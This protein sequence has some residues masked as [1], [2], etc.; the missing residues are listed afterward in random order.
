MP[1][2]SKVETERRVE[3]V[4]KMLLG[5]AT[6]PDIREF[7]CAPEQ[8][9]DVSDTQ[10]RRYMTAAHQLIR[11]RFEAKADYSFNR[12]MLR[13][14][15]L[16]AHAMGAGDFGTALRVLQ[17]E[18]KLEGLYPPTKIAPTNPEGDKPYD[19]VTL[20][21]AERL[22]ALQNLRAQ[23][24]APDGGASADGADD[25]GGSLLG[26][27]PGGDDGRG[28]DPGPLAGGTADELPE[29]GADPG[30]EAEWQ[31]PG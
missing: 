20:T 6:F 15:Q 7:G 19:S 30:I 8:Q 14:E 29:E 26:L 23:V 22:A 1:R 13:R 31:E 10:I 11:E 28:I 3:Q 27:P 2:S 17:D 16:F 12:H 21:E 5:G 18:A 24:G 4:Y 25:P 9:W